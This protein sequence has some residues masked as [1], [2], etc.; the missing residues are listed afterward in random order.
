MN[1]R[2]LVALGVLCALAILIVVLQYR[3][4]AKVAPSRSLDNQM[5]SSSNLSRMWLR[6]LDNRTVFT[7][8]EDIHVFVYIDSH[9]EPVTGFDV[10]LESNI[11]DLK[12]EKATVI[13]SSF[14]LKQTGAL[15]LT[16]FLPLE[17]GSTGVTLK[18]EPVAE[19]IFKRTQMGPIILKVLAEKGE[20]RDSNVVAVE[21]PGDTLGAAEGTTVYVGKQIPLSLNWPPHPFEG[22]ALTLTRIDKPSQPCADCSTKAH[23]T[24]SA[25]NK[26]HELIF[27]S[28]GITGLPSEAQKV[29][30]YVIEQDPHPDESFG[31]VIARDL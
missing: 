24:F 17:G 28:G 8:D 16:G 5:T 2:L 29:E 27:S 12:I 21:P 11:A 19:L 30:G 3:Q 14:E 31:I 18:E 22:A 9:N 23:V 25:N 13:H 26:T 10:V 15:Q 20:T 7:P 6:T 4:P 1:K